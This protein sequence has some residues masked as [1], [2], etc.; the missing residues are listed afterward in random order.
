MSFAV[1]FCHSHYLYVI[2]ASLY[3]IPAQAGIHLL[4]FFILFTISSLAYTS[5]SLFLHKLN[6][7]YQR[8]ATN[9]NNYTLF[10]YVNLHFPT[11]NLFILAPLMSFRHTLCHFCS[12]LS[13]PRKRES[14][15]TTIFSQY[16]QIFTLFP[17]QKL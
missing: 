10:L 13:F 9:L 16:S 6:T 8:L 14:I 11:N 15:L 5:N 12:H 7:K 3:V 4:Y 2:S 1:P 17:P